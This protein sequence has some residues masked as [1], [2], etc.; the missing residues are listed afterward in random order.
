MKD[1]IITYS[2]FVGS[3]VAFFVLNRYTNLAIDDFTYK[4]IFTTNPHEVG[5]RVT[6]FADLV[7]SMHTHYFITNGRIILNGIAQLFLMSDNKLWFD[8][9]NTVV[10]GLFQLLFLQ[11]AGVKFKDLTVSLY[12]FFIS[13]VW[14]LLPAPNHTLLWL[15]GS[16]NY[17]WASVIIFL[18]LLKWQQYDEKFNSVRPVY[19][20]LLFLLG[21]IAGLSHEVFSVGVSGALFF[22]YLLNLK[23]ISRQIIPLVS[24]LFIGTTVTVFAPG[25]MVRMAAGESA[26]VSVAMFLIQRLG[27]FFATFAAMIPVW[28]LLTLVIFIWFRNRIVCIEILKRNIILFFSILLSA[29]FILLVGAYQDRVFWGISLFSLLLFFR[30]IHGLSPAWYQGRVFRI[31]IIV[32]VVAMSVEYA[33]VSSALRHNKQAFDADEN[34]W[35]TSTDSVFA[36]HD[37]QQNRFTCSG[38]GGIDKTFW[39]NKVMSWYYGK[40]SMMFLPDEL[41]QHLYMKQDM[42]APRNKLSLNQSDFTFYHLPQSSFIV[43][44]LN[45]SLHSISANSLFIRFVPKWP[46]QIVDLSVKQKIVKLFLGKLPEPLREETVQAFALSTKNGRY[47]ISGL[48]LQISMKDICRVC[49]IYK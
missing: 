30:I 10:F 42:V 14:F 1:K 23:K 47:L 33:S 29:L 15:D 21:F 44:P 6:S 27:G 49:I 31:I 37:K 18:F 19:Y 25:N 3:L 39:S 17:L 34:Q 36:L 7:Q 16:C 41:Y 9:A 35:R 11:L 26:P 4:H 45:D 2:L 28:A 43:T 12:L 24:G 22:Y 8:I 38:L 40:T 48:P 20:P 46:V 13:L 32:S 5:K